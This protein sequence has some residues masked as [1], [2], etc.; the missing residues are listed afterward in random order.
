MKSSHS[1]FKFIDS[2]KEYRASFKYVYN[3]WR[4]KDWVVCKMLCQLTLQIL[5]AKQGLWQLYSTI[6]DLNWYRT[7]IKNSTFMKK[8]G[9]WSLWFKRSLAFS[10]SHRQW[11]TKKFLT[12]FKNFTWVKSRAIERSH[13]SFREMLSKKLCRS[14]FSLKISFCKDIFLENP[15]DLIS[16]FFLKKFLT[17]F[18]PWTIQLLKSRNFLWKSHVHTNSIFIRHVI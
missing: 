5:H 13:R 1:H 10:I 18:K 7:Q 17:L 8:W 4:R 2:S 14:K 6:N 11:V 3:Y 16:T 12:S 15:Q 9:Y